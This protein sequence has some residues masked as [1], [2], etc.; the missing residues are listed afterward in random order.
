MGG[1]GKPKKEPS[2][3][4]IP[5]VRAHLAK[6]VS[7]FLTNPDVGLNRVDYTRTERGLYNDSD[8]MLLLSLKS[9][10]YGVMLPKSFCV[11]LT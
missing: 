3:R 1:S 8:T 6:G 2:A 9:D 7:S 4:G 5:C 11:A 10:G